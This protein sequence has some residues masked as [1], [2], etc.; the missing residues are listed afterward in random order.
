MAKINID[1]ID[2]L[3]KELELPVALVSQLQN[4]LRFSF[5]IGIESIEKI[6]DRNI[7]NINPAVREYLENYTFDLIKGMNTELANKLRSTLQRGMM[8]GQN[9]RVI[10]KEVKKIF[11]TTKHRAEMIARTET[12]RAYNFGAYSAAKE[13]G[14]KY[15]YY[16]A[17]HDSRTCEMCRRLARKYSRERAI[18]ITQ[19]F[20]DDVSGVR[21]MFP[22]LHVKSRSEVIFIPEK[23]N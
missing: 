18:P 21:G 12:S 19:E 6:L 16:S 15:K 2:R 17:I 13:S 20:I 7:L 11:D 22:P 8:Q 3:F 5:E 1:D 10:A 14:I 23:Y 9:S 4:D